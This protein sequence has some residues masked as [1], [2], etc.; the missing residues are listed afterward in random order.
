MLHRQFRYGGDSI[1]AACVKLEALESRM[2]LTVVAAGQ[3]LSWLDADGDMLSVTFDGPAGSQVSVVNAAGGDIIAGDNIGGITITSSNINSKLTVMN[4]GAGGG[5]TVIGGAGGIATTGAFDMGAIILDVEEDL[6]SDG[7]VTIA[8]A[9]GITVGGRLGMLLLGGEMDCAA[10]NFVAAGG[11]IGIIFIAGD[12]TLRADGLADL[13]AGAGGAGDISILGLDGLV[14][15]SGGAEVAPLVVGPGSVVVAD[16]FGAGATGKVTISTT[17]GGSLSVWAV[18]VVGGGSVVAE[19]SIDTVG[20]NAN[21]SAAGAPAGV[22]F[23]FADLSSAGNV[24]LRGTSVDVLAVMNVGGTMGMISNASAGGDIFMVDVQGSC[25]GIQ[26]TGRNS[27]LGGIFSGNQPITQ[28]MGTGTFL[29]GGDLGVFKGTCI[30]N[31]FLLAN[32]NIGTVQAD[33]MLDSTVQSR[34]NIASVKANWMSGGQVWADGTLG[35]VG[36]GA[37]GADHST[38]QGIGGIT[39]F[40]CRGNLKDSQVLSLFDAGDFIPMVGGVIQSFSAGSMSGG[41][42]QALG[43]LGNVSI[44]GL[45]S[46]ATVETAF[47]DWDLGNIMVGGGL[48]RFSAGGMDDHAKLKVLRDAGAVSVGRQGMSK[49]G[50]IE[51]LGNA[52]GVSVGGGMTDD[53]QVFVGGNAARPI[54]V[55]GDMLSSDIRVDG[56]AAGVS[57]GGDMLGLGQ[58]LVVG[59]VPTINVRGCMIGEQQLRVQGTAGNVKVGGDFAG[60]G[61]DSGMRFDGAVG[62]ISIGGA[63]T[64]TQVEAYAAVNAINIRGGA[65]QTGFI[66]NGMTNTMSVGAGMDQCNFTGHMINAMNVRGAIDNCRID[67]HE[68]IGA[69]TAGGRMTHTTMHVHDFDALGNPTTGGI[70]LIKASEMVNCHF[71]T[72]QDIK[73]VAVRG[74]IKGCEFDTRAINQFHNL[75]TGVL[76]GGGGIGTFA[77]GDLVGT[78]MH[79]FGGLGLMK[80]GGGIDANTEIE[81]LDALTGNIGTI[82]CR[83]YVQGTISAAGNVAAVLSA[84]G[85]ASVGAEPQDYLFID[86]HY[87]LTGGSLSA[88]GTIGICS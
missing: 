41:N 46:D 63:M 51:L 66:L 72:H 86:K 49:G 2:F 20:A 69:V 12:L 17:P 71:A 21:I 77:C 80:V 27:N 79:L 83:G 61:D 6:F 58:I 3:S 55:R 78:R 9:E 39:N 23:V 60:I 42:V 19:V 15:A 34:L 7:L 28:N 64:N 67:F 16:D 73:A 74:T 22:G 53:A 14:L 13:T 48:V 26:A 24:T 40:A 4:D 88:G 35:N 37:G 75:E 68:K 76:V 59:N 62:T 33:S 10:G 36:I 1:G 29:V 81:T 32:G 43:G 85:N 31:A 5:T 54:N 38:F 57:V 87:L 50:F 82:N 11:D 47:S 70:D 45:M 30:N 65:S 56:N 52:Q 25:L 8:G 84:G 44:R 18:P